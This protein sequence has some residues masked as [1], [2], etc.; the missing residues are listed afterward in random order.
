MERDREVKKETERGVRREE[1][2]S[3]EEDG[4]GVFA[5]LATVNTRGLSLWCLMVTKFD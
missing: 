3:E 1:G 2:N 5:E 4:F